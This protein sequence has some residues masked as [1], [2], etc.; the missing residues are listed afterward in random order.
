MQLTEGEKRRVF[1]WW[2]RTGR[3]PT[4]RTAAGLELKFNPYHDPHNGRF[5]FGPGG[6]GSVVA[7]GEGQG[8]RFGRGSNSRAFEDPMT[9][10]QAFPEL[11][12]PV[13]KTFAAITG[14]LFDI[15]GPAAEAQIQILDSHATNV[16]EDIKKLDPQFVYQEITSPHPS[17]EARAARLDDLMLWRAAIHLRKTG[18][19]GPLQTAMLPRMQ[20]EVDKAYRNGQDLLKHGKL[21][22]HGVNDQM[23]LG[24]YV[25]KEV[26]NRIRLALDWYGIKSAAHGR[27]KV[28]RRLY[29]DGNGES[30]GIPDVM[31][32]D[33]IIEGSLTRKTMSLAQL[34]RFALG[35]PKPRYIVVV[36]PTG[37]HARHTYVYKLP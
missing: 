35:R 6:T 29:I 20:R 18:N 26:R 4:V 34:R 33:V 15:V 25:D 3:L 5:T 7:Y 36:T 8:P 24:N 31:I 10:E 19:L 27:V 13:S 9:V 37:T 1:A 17:V 23:K 11:D 14:P 12:D 28:N 21:K 32:D 2:L 30:Y 22:A 16:L